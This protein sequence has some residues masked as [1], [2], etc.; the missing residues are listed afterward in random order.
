MR[1]QI[2]G[3]HITTQAGDAGKT[4]TG[5]SLELNEQASGQGLVSKLKLDGSC[6]IV[7]ETVL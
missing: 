7:L 5:R 2:S 3:T 1:N 4:E 6:G